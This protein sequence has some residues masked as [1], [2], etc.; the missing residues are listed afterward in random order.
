MFIHPAAIKPVITVTN[1]GDIKSGHIY[2]RYQAENRLI[3]SAELQ[4]IVEERIRELSETILT[5]H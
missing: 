5:K 1:K 3:G 2:Y 4:N